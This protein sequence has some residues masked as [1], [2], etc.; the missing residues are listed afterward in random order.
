MIDYKTDKAYK[1]AAWIEREKNYWRMSKTPKYNCYRGEIYEID[2]GE[3]VGS[4]LSGRHLGLVLQDSNPYTDRVLVIPLSSK[5]EEYNSRDIVEFLIGGTKITSKAS[6]VVNETRYISKLRIFSRSLLFAE[7]V[8]KGQP[9][10]I[11]INLTDENYESYGT[12]K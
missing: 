3:N 2:F 9:V 8:E 10:G 11:A 7:H 6:I 5:I 4:E 12:F 1:R